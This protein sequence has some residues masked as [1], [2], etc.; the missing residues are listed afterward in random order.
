MVL[1]FIEIGEVD[2]SNKD[3]A[4]LSSAILQ[5]FIFWYTNEVDP[6]EADYCPAESEHL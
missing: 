6:C 5:C 2:Q 1:E 3:V 4:D